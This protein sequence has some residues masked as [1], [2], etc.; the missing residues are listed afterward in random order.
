MNQL[1]STR[2]FHAATEMFCRQCGGRLGSQ[3]NFCGECGT[4][5]EPIEIF[6]PVSGTSVGFVA[7]APPNAILAND[8]A[9]AIKAFLK[10]RLAVVGMIALIGPLG[11]PALWF[12]PR[13]TTR[14]KVITT[15]AYVL[16]TTVVPLAVAWYWLDYSLRP[17]VDV[18]GQ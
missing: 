12:S 9:P 6:D 13:F 11:L 10:N 5:S 2:Q 8:G 7:A 17:L 16:M 4:G 14:T 3:D 18:F 15:S 1:I